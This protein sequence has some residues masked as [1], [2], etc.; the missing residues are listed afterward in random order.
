M[1]VV[2][3]ASMLFWKAAA[4]FIQSLDHCRTE[5]L[6]NMQKDD[7]LPPNKVFLGKRSFPTVPVVYI[8]TTQAEN[9]PAN[10]TL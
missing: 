1:S 5:I 3:N 7:P 2:K 8:P 4:S 6:A 9:S 10:L